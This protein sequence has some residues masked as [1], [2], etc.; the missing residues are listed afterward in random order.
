MT[1]FMKD[2]QRLVMERRKRFKE[3]L[4][5][6]TLESRP[7]RVKPKGRIKGMGRL[8]LRKLLGNA[9]KQPS[10]IPNKPRRQCREGGGGK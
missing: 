3:A 1:P 6:A 9:T 8:K 5:L 7:Y 2:V 4:Y 10:T